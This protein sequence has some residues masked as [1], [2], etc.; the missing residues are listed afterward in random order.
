MTFYI[1]YLTDLLGAK[2]S[3]VSVQWEVVNNVVVHHCHL[4]KFT[5]VLAFMF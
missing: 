2:N 5:E 3:N 1:P 4:K